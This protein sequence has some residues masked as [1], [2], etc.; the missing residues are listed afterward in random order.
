MRRDTRQIPYPHWDRT[1]A[2]PIR[3]RLTARLSDWW[4][5]RQDARAG[6]P[7][8]DSEFDPSGREHAFTP[9]LGTLQRTA[10]DAMDHEL[11]QLERERTDPA[12][13]L[14]SVVARAVA[15]RQAITTATEA[16][17]ALK[18]PSESELAARR[19]GETH[20]AED[21]VRR[22]R[23]AGH[24]E[25]RAALEATRRQAEEQ[26]TGLLREEAVLRERISR[27]EAVAAARARRIHEYAWRRANS[28]WQRL[29]RR[30]PS[31]GQLNRALR[32]TG[33]DLPQ[34]AQIRPGP[35]PE[36]VPVAP[37]TDSL[38]EVRP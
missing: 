32:P 11:L 14:A 28:Y 25:R 33:P 17:T 38:P 2:A 24:L 20:T 27:L 10:S 16:L 35:E 6:I 13:E 9:H 29:V 3:Y 30:H 23:M 15:A 4:N 34:W 1:P 19:A 22:R 5:G 8:L 7:A 37:A 26:L 12:R 18:P 36:D 21:V 31:G